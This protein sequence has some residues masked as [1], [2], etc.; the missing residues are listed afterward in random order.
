M[1]NYKINENGYL[2]NPDTG[3]LKHRELAYEYIYSRN[4]SYFLKPFSEYVVHHL[5]GNTDNYLISN[6]LLIPEYRHR[7]LHD[8]LASGQKDQAL[9]LQ[10]ELKVK[11]AYYKYWSAVVK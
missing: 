8:L 6:L 5:D 3:N 7:E 4:P 9:K 11:Y 10:E 1:G 2:V